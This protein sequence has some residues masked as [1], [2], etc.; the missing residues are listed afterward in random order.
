MLYQRAYNIINLEVI[1]TN[2]M[3][4]GKIFKQYFNW[5]TIAF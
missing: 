2:I 3:A 1:F 4:I 5:N